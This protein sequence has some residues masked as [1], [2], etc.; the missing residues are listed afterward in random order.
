MR[1]VPN[2]QF[3]ATLRI[4]QASRLLRQVAA[5]DRQRRSARVSCTE[6]RSTNETFGDIHWPGSRVACR[7]KPGGLRGRARMGPTQCSA[8]DLRAMRLARLEMWILQ[9]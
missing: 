4:S 9:P 1:L 5:P 7:D 3:C 8:D 6:Q 2:V